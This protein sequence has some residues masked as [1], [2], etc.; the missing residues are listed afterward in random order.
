[1]N[2][3]KL[4]Q[5]DCQRKSQKWSFVENGLSSVDLFHV[6]RRF[7]KYSTATGMKSSEMYEG[8]YGVRLCLQVTKSI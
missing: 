2:T 5:R 3:V 8:P 1:M 4:D 6:S 7:A